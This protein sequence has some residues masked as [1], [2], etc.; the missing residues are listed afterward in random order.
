MKRTIRASVGV[1]WVAGRQLRSDRMRTV[2]AVVGVALAV[3]S[4]TLL[5]GVGAGVVATGNEKFDESGRD[6]WVSGGPIDIAPGSVG[7]FRNPIP[8]AHPLADEIAAHD[9]VKTAVPM[10]FQIVYVSTDG[11]E[12]ETTV[13][14]GVPGAGGSSVSLESGSGFSGPNTHYAGGSYDGEMT[15]QAIVSPE[16]AAEFDLEVGDTIHVG[17]TIANARRNEFEVVG[18][19]PTFANFLGTGTVTLRLSELQTLTGN[20]YGDRATLVTIQTA[21]GADPAAVRDELAA[22]HPEYTFRTNREQLVSLLERQAVVLAAGVSLVGLGV[23]SGGILALNVLL[24]IIYIQRRSLS[25]LRAVGATRR[26]VVGVALVE[27]AAVAAGGYLV[28]VAVTPL[29][30]TGL[31][32]L[33]LAVTGFDGLVQVP[34]YAYA[35]GAGVACGFALLGGTLGAWRVARVASANALTR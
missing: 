7:G 16:T 35:V 27:S 14:S 4:V 24:S 15:H 11:E 32:R 25:I 21:P 31:N 12:F 1:V 18:I 26:S 2:L 17:G 9:G 29:A 13:G 10:A 20:A 19:S 5:A 23:I 33:A 34:T 3:L 28:A 8:N 6:L 30:A 22:E